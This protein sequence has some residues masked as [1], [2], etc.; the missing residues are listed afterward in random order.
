LQGCYGSHPLILFS[1]AWNCQTHAGTILVDGILASTYVA[2]QSHQQEHVM[3]RSGHGDGW[4]VPWLNQ[5]TV[6]HL[7]LSPLRLTCQFVSGKHCRDLQDDGML[8]F[9]AFGFKVVA[10]AESQHIILQM[11]VLCAILLVTGIF[12]GI[13]MLLETT[14]RTSAVG[15]AILAILLF[16]RAR[17]TSGK[18]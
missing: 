2:V 1:S 6:L 12:Y 18:C 8:T 17:N 5:A 13:E 16:H 9:V 15:G 10:W 14:L 11:A 7:W 3:F 4:S